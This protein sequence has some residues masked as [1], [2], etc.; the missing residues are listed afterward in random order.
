MLISYEHLR[1]HSSIS[2]KSMQ[3]AIL[4]T[5]TTGHN[6]YGNIFI[7]HFPTWWH[8]E[9]LQYLHRYLSPEVSFVKSEWYQ[10]P[11]Q[12]KLKIISRLKIVR[13]SPKTK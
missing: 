9:N 12:L 13:H 1:G 10:I 5:H 2:L 6:L 8:Q 4:S 3:L 11:F 7:Q